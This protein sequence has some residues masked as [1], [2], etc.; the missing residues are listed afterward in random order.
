MD[1]EARRSMWAIIEKVS[2]ERSVVL[3]SHSMEGD[4]R[5]ALSFS[6]MKLRR[7]ANL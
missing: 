7:I 4:T 1:P 2:A 5:F 6:E 3:V